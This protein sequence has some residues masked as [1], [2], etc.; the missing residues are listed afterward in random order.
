MHQDATWYG[1]RPQPGD[2]VLDSDPAPCQKRGRSPC[3]ILT[4]EDE[5][6]EIGLEVRPLPVIANFVAT[7]QQTILVKTRSESV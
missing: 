7:E 2:F 3:P 4:V 6:L 1:G 5:N